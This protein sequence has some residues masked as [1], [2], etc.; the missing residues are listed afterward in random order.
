MANHDLLV[1]SV[2]Q[3]KVAEELGEEVVCLHVVLCLYFAFKAV[4][5]VKLLGLVVASAH[6]EV[7]RE[8]DF[9][10]EH[11]HNDFD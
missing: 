7:L 11:K 9:P 4:H 8:A 2:S 1:D 3:W 10:G 5:F 6:E